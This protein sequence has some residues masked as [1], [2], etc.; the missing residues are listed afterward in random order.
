ML[1]GPYKTY[2]DNGAK[3]AEGEFRSQRRHGLFIAY[4]PNGKIKEQ[5]EY[6]ADRKHKD[7]N[8]YDEQGNL[9]RTFVFKAGLL[10]E[11]KEKK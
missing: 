5:G 10:V 3:E 1:N 2:Y 9:V 11:T 7:W 4:H 6:I 8:E